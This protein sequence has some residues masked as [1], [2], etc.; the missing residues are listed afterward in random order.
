[1]IAVVYISDNVLADY[2]HNSECGGQKKHEVK[3]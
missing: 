1:M 3:V 2:S